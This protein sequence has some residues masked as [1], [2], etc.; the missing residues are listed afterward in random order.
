MRRDPIHVLLIEDDEVDATQVRRTLRDEP[1]RFQLHWVT[2]LQEGLDHLGKGEV[3]AVL[4]DLNLPDSRGVETVVRLRERAPS[5][6]IVVLTVAI[7]LRIALGTLQA[8]AQD[9]LLKDELSISSV[10]T[11]AIR[12]AIERQKIAYEQRRLEERVTRAEKMASLGVLAAGVALGFNRLLGTILED[13]DDA[14]E[15]VQGSGDPQRL[16]RRL[17]SIRQAA[18]RAGRMADQLR[19]YAA[20][21]R[22]HAAPIDLSEFVTEASGF[23]ETIAGD[24]VELSYDLSAS[25]P[26]VQAA[27]IQLH[28]I[29]TSL[30][31]NAREAV[32]DRRGRVA[33]STGSRRADRELLAR[34]HGNPEP[35]EGLYTFL[36]VRD[37]GS[38]IPPEMLD[39]IFD[40]FFTTKFAG[41]GLGLAAVLGVLRELRAVVLVES[42]PPEGSSFTVFFPAVTLAEPTRG[43]GAS[44]SVQ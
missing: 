9:F 32:G 20:T 43:Q 30:V 11:R 2:T 22:A 26:P 40:P 41:R 7:E 6:P 5:L 28:E 34:T 17:N 35:P 10:L 14:M 36:Q 13:A 21:S 37:D 23:L 24:G 29:L 38:G 44:Q 19:E 33:I 39:R 8:G 42:Q 12:Y 1:G 25:T 18:L 15:L 3:D 27:R 4:L 31:T 16:S